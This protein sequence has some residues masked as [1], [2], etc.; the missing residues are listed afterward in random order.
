MRNILNIYNQATSEEIQNG[1]NWYAEANAFAD[2][3]SSYFGIDA[4]KCAAIIAATSPM[5]FWQQ[6]KQCAF[7]FFNSGYKT[8]KHTKVFYQKCLQI[9]EAKNEDEILN[10]LKGEKIKNFY[11]NI[12]RFYDENHCTIDRHAIRIYRGLKTN[13]EKVQDLSLSKREYDKIKKS[14]I[15]TAKKLNLLPLQL[16]AITWVT[17]KRIVE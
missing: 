10:I 1:L 3:L 7:E 5:K 12:H 16:Q 2:D 9:L 11:L 6:N 17:F 4:Q 15:R 13:K 14:Y 8:A